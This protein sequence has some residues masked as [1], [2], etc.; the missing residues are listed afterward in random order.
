MSLTTTE[1]APENRGAH[2]AAARRPL[3]L[4]GT[5]TARALRSV[6]AR[7]FHLAV[8]LF[9]RRGGR[10]LLLSPN[11]ARRQVMFDRKQRKFISI[12]IR[13]KVDFYTIGQVYLD[14]D[15]GLDKLRRQDDLMAYYRSIEQS[16]K[17]PLI[18]DCGGNTGLATRYFSENYPQA[19]IVCI[20]PDP[21][22]LAQARKN[23]SSPNIVFMENA[24]GSEKSRGTIV[25][26]GLGNN[27]YR[28]S[29]ADDGATEIV[30]INGILEQFDA[31]AYTPFIVKI[32]IEGFESELFSKNLEWIEKFPLLVIELH[33]WMLPRSGNANNFIKAIA[34][35]QRDFVYH[36]ENV[37]S[38][39]NTLL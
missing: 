1:I 12:D 36:G 15:Y 26:P 23:N 5:P 28:I 39:S 11:H 7:L 4:P 16:G 25:D 35:L 8:F 34:P 31:N 17:K 9:R 18:I 22:N 19:K 21:A 3:F 2:R 27:G 24:I 37:F 14:E 29:C 30:S 32:D 13:D 20:E 10:Y 6:A 33:D 38:I